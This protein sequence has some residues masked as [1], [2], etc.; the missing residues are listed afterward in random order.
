[1]IIELYFQYSY[2]A[3]LISKCTRG[4]VN[5]DCLGKISP[6]Y[7]QVFHIISSDFHAVMPEQPVVEKLVSK[8]YLVKYLVCIIFNCS[9]EDN[10]LRMSLCVL[11][12]GALYDEHKM[13]CL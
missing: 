4:V 8:V 13:K 6:Q 3:Y 9:S 10:D 1:M 7:V 5:D 2:F 12:N 11:V